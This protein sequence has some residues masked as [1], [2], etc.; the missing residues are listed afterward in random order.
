MST[1]RI[2]KQIVLKAPQSRVW[3]ALTDSAQFGHWFG[4]KFDAPFTVGARMNGSI[5]GTKV[6]SEV[7]KMQ[8]PYTGKPFTII[9]DRI[10]P[11]NHF[12]FRWHP[13]AADP[14]HDYDAEP[15]T[16]VEFTLKPVS[17]G[18]LLTVTES[19]FDQLPP[20]RRAEAFA[21]NEGG[22]EIQTTLIDAYLNQKA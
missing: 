8:E 1:D 19:G 7:A 22:W 12:S 17:D 13:Y 18:V 2:E 21:A 6:N 5:V 14:D 9:V 3:E 16:L 15:M 10:E 20:E 11:Q 4:A